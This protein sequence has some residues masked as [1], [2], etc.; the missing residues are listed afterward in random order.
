MSE[1]KDRLDEVNSKDNIDIFGDG[2][3]AER[4]EDVKGTMKRFFKDL[5]KQKAKIL[6]ILICI[7]VASIFSIITP[8]LIGRAIDQIFKGI[9]SATSE[10]RVFELNISTMGNI[11]FIIFILYVLN[12]MF[13]YLQQHAMASISQ[14]FSL[15]MRKSISGKLNRLP[16]SYYDTHKKGDIL[17]RITSDMEK[18]SDTLQ[19][20]LTQILTSFVTI[21]GAFVMMMVIS[22]VLTLIAFISIVA[23]M[24]VAALI[25]T[26]THGYY[27]KNQAALGELN[28]NIEEAFT[29][30]LVIKAFNLQEQMIKTNDELNE[31]MRKE[32]S[33]AQFIT[34]VINPIVRLIGQMG[35]VVVAVKGALSVIS[36]TISIGDIQAIFQYINQISEPVTQFAFT[37]NSLQGAI[38][39]IERVYKIIDEKEEI[40]DATDKQK[41]LLPK[42][43]I[44]FEHVSFGYSEDKILMNDVNINVKAGSKIAI[45]GPTGAGK[46]TLVNLLMRFYELKS[47][48][49]TIDGVNI[50]EISRKELRSILGMVLQDTW[51]FNGTIAE[52]IA[53]GREDA[54]EDEIKKAAKAARIDHFIRTLPQGYQTVLDDEVTG[55]SVGQKQLITIARA[56][57]AD[58][59]ILI[60][61]EATSSVDTRT[62]IEIQKAMKNLMKGRTSFVIAHRLST[63]RDSD[64][65]LVMKEGTII[66]QGT[67]NDL[68]SQRG[69]YEELYNSQFMSKSSVNINV[70]IV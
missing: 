4:A 27:A 33:K 13:N 26:K 37:M 36:G 60:L 43:N 69:F 29:G 1:E 70:N 17:S 64:L 66:E 6:T 21:I 56:I 42:G 25:S 53:Y 8:K 51:L 10:N 16:L 32:S 28:A 31:K 3:S 40:Q 38:A 61:D 68:M 30:N 35:Y 47:G 50:S 52:N 48:K 23:S 12:A 19:E 2:I 14:Q 20:G 58:P 9:Q 65:I 59:T 55:M 15:D 39:S 34:Y 67:H 7:V 54:S 45:V 57:L 11:V 24:A 46:T 41:I 5:M 44:R 63:I 18:V 22:P 49:I 62:E